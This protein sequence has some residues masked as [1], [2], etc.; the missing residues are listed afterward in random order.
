MQISLC[1][2]IQHLLAMHEIKS[3]LVKLGH[4]VYLPH[5][6]EKFIKNN[7]FSET[8]DAH[9]KNMY[10]KKHLDK[11]KKSDAVLIVNMEKNGVSGYIGGNTF[12]EMGFAMSVGVKIF[13][14]NTYSQNLS[15]ID[16]I[17]GMLPIVINGDLKKIK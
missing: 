3:E 1:G 13:I 12:L 15:Y 2:S 4:F 7:D 8:P 17:E 6:A 5:N 9:K 16:E 11:I 14:F 10:I